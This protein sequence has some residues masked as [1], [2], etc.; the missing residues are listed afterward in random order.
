[1][2]GS[3]LRKLLAAVSMAVAAAWLA[4]AA[5]AQDQ[6]NVR[7]SWKLKGEYGPLFL[8]QDK[9][10]FEREHLAV[11][12][13][14]GAGA[15][16]ALGSLVQG[17][18][19][20]VVLPGIFALT[21]IQKGIP[22]KIVALY[23]PRTPIVLLS[24]P[25]KPVRTPKDLEGKTI[26][27]S[28]GETGTAYLDAFCRLNGVDCARVKRVTMNDQARYPNFL[29]R[30]V[31]VVSAYADTDLPLIEATQTTQFV[32]LDMIRYGLSVPGLA[33]VTSDA[34]IAKKSAVLKRFLRAVA[35]G[36]AEARSDNAAATRALLKSW[37]AAPDARI[38]AE[39][40]R[41]TVAAIPVPAGHPTGWIDG[42]VIEHSLRMMKSVGEI[43]DPKPVDAYFTNALLTDR[44]G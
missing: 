27:T 28:V 40:I 38:V 37:A 14:E 13:G 20:A 24:F 42:A 30:Q 9:G 10:Y 11:R 15:Q 36:I 33:I 3:R 43:G 5:E 39:Q 17:Q 22:A 2:T 19:D 44:Q 25:D 41:L 35:A 6:V 7:F 4:P 8:A 21:A 23:H 1:M 32:Q 34:D 31:D 29:Q 12:L 16:A 18:E 26:A